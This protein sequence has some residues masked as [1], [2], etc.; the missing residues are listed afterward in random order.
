MKTFVALFAMASGI[1]YGGYGDLPDTFDETT[2]Y[3]ITT[4]GQDNT[5]AQSFY[6]G[7]HWSDGRPP[8]DY[9]PVI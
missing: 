1:V 6:Y 4:G 2:G 3:V 8:H 7:T 9:L 5:S